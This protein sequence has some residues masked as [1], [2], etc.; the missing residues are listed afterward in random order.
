MNHNVNSQNVDRLE[1]L[2]LLT[3]Q[4]REKRG[5]Y[6]TS[7]IITKPIIIRNNVNIHEIG[8]AEYRIFN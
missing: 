5:Y 6:F 7:F 4:M 2:L 3:E 1:R 8:K